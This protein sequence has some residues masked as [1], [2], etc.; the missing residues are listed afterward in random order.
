MVKELIMRSR[1]KTNAQKIYWNNLIQVVGCIAC[2]KEGIYN[3]YCSIHHIDGHTKKLAHWLI[4]PLC[5]VHHQKREKNV[6]ARHPDKAEFERKYGK[7]Y[8]L[9]AEC[10]EILQNARIIVPVPVIEFL[11]G[12][13]LIEV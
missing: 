11:Q 8:Q 9:M 2:R 5:G 4:I 7:E 12:K 3:D 1:S 10:V 13:G 6:V